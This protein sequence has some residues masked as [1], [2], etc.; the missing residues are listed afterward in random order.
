M[1]KRIKTCLAQTDLFDTLTDEQLVK[2]EAIVETAVLPKDIVL[3]EEQ[4]KSDALFIIAS[5]SVHIWL[6][7]AIISAEENIAEPVLVAE[8]VSGQVFGEMALVDQGIRSATAQ[9]AQENTHILRLPREKLIEL[10]D[11][12]LDLGYKIMKNLAADLA[13]KMR[14]TGLTLR[15]YQ[16]MLSHK[17]KTTEA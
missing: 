3:I 2:I 1:Q 7:T 6:N 16:V 11:S 9:T 13:Q 15:Q 4:D 12:D 17:N 10:C 5:G 8:L 14:N